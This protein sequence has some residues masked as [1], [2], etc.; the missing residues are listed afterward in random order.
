MLDLQRDIAKALEWADAVTGPVLPSQLSEPY[1]S[2]LVTLVKHVLPCHLGC[3]LSPSP[4][5]H[6]SIQNAGPVTQALFADLIHKLSDKDSNY[7]P[8]SVSN[9]E[10]TSS[11]EIDWEVEESLVVAIVDSN[12]PEPPT[13]KS[14]MADLPDLSFSSETYMSSSPTSLQFPV[15]LDDILTHKDYRQVFLEIEVVERPT[16]G[17]AMS[18]V[19]S[20]GGLIN[21]DGFKVECRRS[22]PMLVCILKG[23]AHNAK[24]YSSTGQDQ[25]L[26]YWVEGSDGEGFFQDTLM[27]FICVEGRGNTPGHLCC[28]SCQDSIYQLAP[29]E[30][31]YQC[32]DCLGTMLVCQ[33]CVVT[34][35]QHLPLHIIQ[36]WTG[37]HFEKVALCNLG[38]WIQLSYERS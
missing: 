27:E 5:L 16:K 34:S 13:L 3:E 10:Y 17:K 38:L 1:G 29:G 24:S 4:L 28:L 8:D 30:A 22:H 36:R 25:P 11:S 19:F 18:D 20:S 7:D 12:G 15:Y 14:L 23:R 35:H 33:V 9:G 6:C 37:Y 2:L 21:G 32:E 26:K 31:R